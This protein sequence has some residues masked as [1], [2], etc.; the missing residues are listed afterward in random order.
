MKTELEQLNNEE[1]MFINGGAPSKKTSFA[2]DL[3]YAISWGIRELCDPQF[4]I[5]WEEAIL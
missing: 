1:L 4:W 3:A 2:Y 5:E